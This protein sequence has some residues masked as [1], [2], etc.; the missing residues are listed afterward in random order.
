LRSEPTQPGRPQDDLFVVLYPELRRLAAA[1]LRG[2]CP[3][4]QPTALVHEAWLRMQGADPQRFHDRT[5]FLA[6]AATVIRQ[7]LVEHVRARRRQKRGGGQRPKTL[8]ESELAAAAEDRLDLLDLEAVL[9]DLAQ[10]DPRKARVV[11]LRVFAGATIDETAA[12]LDVSHMT[13]S[14]DW[15]MAKAWIVARLRR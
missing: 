13:V 15:R 8:I 10:L 3:S 14:N 4:V 12:C 5:H 2:R 7:L 1:R 9:V 6:T 11:E